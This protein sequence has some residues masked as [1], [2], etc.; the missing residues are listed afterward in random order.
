MLIEGK[1][2]NLW[3]SGSNILSKLVS[4]HEPVFCYRDGQTGVIYGRGQTD[5]GFWV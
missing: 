3:Q 2:L 1:V 4:Q 5:I